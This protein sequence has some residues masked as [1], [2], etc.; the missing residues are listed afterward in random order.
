MR[1]R[2]AYALKVAAAILALLVLPACTSLRAIEPV[3]APPAQFQLDRV[4][5]VEFRDVMTVGQ[6][7]AERG[8]NFFGLPG[9]NSGACGDPELI[10][11]PDPCDA[12]I[13]AYAAALCVYVERQTRPDVRPRFFNAGFNGLTSQLKFTV[14]NLRSLTPHS[15]RA[16]E[17]ELT[18]AFVH[19]DLALAR[20]AARG[21][22]VQEASPGG[23]VVCGNEDSLILTNP[24]LSNE[25][26][27]FTATL[28]HELAHANGWAADHH[29]GSYF[30]QGSFVSAN[31]SEDDILPAELVKAA[32]KAKAANREQA[33]DTA[34]EVVLAEA[35]PSPR[36]N[37]EIQEPSFLQAR[38][39][40]ETAIKRAWTA[41]T[42]LFNPLGF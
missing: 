30:S 33:D 5:A 35:M 3:I 7:C 23:L 9:F 24:C 4:V 17:S 40:A 15:S 16:A 6:R 27:W 22:D 8:A 13:G 34:A 11:M 29:G 19:P 20:C 28:C 38:Q 1:S 26:S 21:L 25:H 32:L 14:A 42:A 37:S 39:A 41:A 2:Q 31:L 18:I 12:D 10:T 36:T